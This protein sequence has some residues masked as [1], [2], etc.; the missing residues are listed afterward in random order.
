ML[1]ED[2]DL[3]NALMENDI[4]SINGLFTHRNILN[5]LNPQIVMNFIGQTIN[6]KSKWILVNWILI[7]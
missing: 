4:N 2:S 3:K 6:S 1:T 7:H 5:Y